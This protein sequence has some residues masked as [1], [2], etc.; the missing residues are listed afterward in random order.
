MFKPRHIKFFSEKKKREKRTIKLKGGLEITLPTKDYSVKDLRN[1]GE[2]GG[3][4]Y[5]YR[6][7]LEISSFGNGVAGETITKYAY[8]YEFALQ[9]KMK[10]MKLR[11]Y[12]KA[13]ASCCEISDWNCDN[14]SLYYKDDALE[15]KGKRQKVGKAKRKKIDLIKI[16]EER[17]TSLLKKEPLKN[18]EILFDRD[19]SGKWR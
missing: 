11:K 4:I 6:N 10:K 2:E 9:R 5:L 13:P 12:C 1:L 3:L 14:C 17:N 18:K 15:R 16:I 19:H 8:G 7:G